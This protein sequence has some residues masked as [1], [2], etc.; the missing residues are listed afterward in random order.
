MRSLP[1]SFIVSY[2]VSCTIVSAGVRRSVAWVNVSVVYHFATYLSCIN[3]TS[4]APSGG[5]CAG[6]TTGVAR[7]ANVMDAANMEARIGF[8]DCCRMVQPVK[9]RPAAPPSQIGA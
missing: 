6:R 5:V 7:A 3:R 4:S 1:G 8:L 2:Q 9:T